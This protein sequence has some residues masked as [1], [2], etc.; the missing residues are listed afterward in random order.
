MNNI[1]RMG[2]PAW[3]DSFVR[4]LD[5]QLASSGAL[6]KRTVWGCGRGAVALALGCVAHAPW[7]RARLQKQDG[8]EL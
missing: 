1:G 4:W 2:L 3:L 7:M 5:T 6:C 8:N